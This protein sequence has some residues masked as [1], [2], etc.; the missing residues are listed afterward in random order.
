M[1]KYPL[2]FCKAAF[3]G[4]PPSRANPMA[5]SNGTAT[6]INVGHGPFAITCAHV[7]EAYRVEL[8]NSPRCFFQIGNCRLDPFAQLTALD[9][10]L[11]FATIKL[12]AAQAQETIHNSNGIGE[13]FYVQEAWPPGRVVVGD[14]VA[15]GGFP[16]DL[17]ELV[18]IAGISFGSYSSGAARVTRSHD[19]YFVCQFERDEWVEHFNEPEPATIGGLSGGPAFVLRHSDAGVISYEFSGVIYE[20]S[21]DYELL[22]VRASGAIPFDALR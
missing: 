5:V 17:R 14:F 9:P 11:D 1:A 13:R 4:E 10:Q 19:N 21:E 22:Y 7:I 3:F 6:L 18:S 8:E 15:F 16:G 20:F 2:R 12:T